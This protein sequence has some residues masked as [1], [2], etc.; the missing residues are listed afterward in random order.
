MDSLL[1]TNLEHFGHDYFN[2]IHTDI[3][4]KYEPLLS[5]YVSNTIDVDSIFDEICVLI[6]NG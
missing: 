6:F 1:D 4:C 3:H 2:Q 5:A